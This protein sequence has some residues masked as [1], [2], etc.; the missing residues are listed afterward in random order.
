MKIKISKLK[1]SKFSKDI[2]SHVPPDDLIESIKMNGVIQ[3]IWI[4]SNNTI[5]SGHRRVNACKKLNIK[6]IECELKEYSDLLVIECNRYRKKTTI[7]ISKECRALIKLESKQ[8]KDRQG[9]RTDL[10]NIKEN[11]P[12]SDK[13]Q[14]R[15][16]V[17]EKYD[18]S[19]KQLEKINFIADKDPE[20]LRP[21]DEGKKTVHKVYNEIKKEEDKEEQL[22]ENKRLSKK[23]KPDS[24]CKII[25]G[26]FTKQ[27]IKK[28]SID[29]IITDPPYGIE[30]IESWK[31]LSIFA[32]KVLKPSGFLLTYSGQ[33][34]LNEVIKRL[35]TKLKYYWI[36]SLQHTGNSQLINSRSIFCGWKPILVFQ[37]LPFKKLSRTIDDTIEGT[38]REKDNHEWQQAQDEVTALIEGFTRVNDLVL[39]PFAGSG[40]I[41]KVCKES[42]RRSIGI[43]KELKHI[44]MIKRR[45]S[46]V[47]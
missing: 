44:N 14:T 18:I 28:N 41:L 25:H 40:T 17:A 22:K 24:S 45:M 12:E 10:D 37:K 31:D 30:Y 43:E 1:E 36:F 21:V 46:W 5:I 11:L 33:L 3:S 16:K 8:S 29:A 27:D 15:D 6:D 19:G 42:K 39:D 35:E 9:T 38:G 4:D 26:D 20:L 32:N 2:Y 34:N 23:Y 7:E 47:K 13:G